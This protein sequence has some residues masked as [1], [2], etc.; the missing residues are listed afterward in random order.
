MSQLFLEI[1][2][3]ALSASWMILAVLL[4]RAVFKKIPKWITCLLWGMVALKLVLPFNIESA[5]SLIPSAR[6]IPADIAY[7]ASPRIDTGV[8]I[9]NGVINP[10]IS[11]SLPSGAAENAGNPF[12]SLLSVLAVIWVVGAAVMI[13]YAI[14]SFFLL[15][16]KV[17]ASFRRDKNIYECDEINIP[18]ILG[19]IRPRIYLPSGMDS[20]AMDCVLEHEQ[21]HIK[22][23]DYFWKPLGFFILSVY[24]FHPLCWAAYILLCKDIEL[25]CDEKATKDKDKEWKAAYCQA[26]LDCNGEKR[27]ITACPVAFGEVGVKDRVKLVLNYKRPS[28]WILAISIVLCIVMAVCFLTDPKSN[29]DVSDYQGIS[30]GEYQKLTGYQAEFYHA[31]YYIGKLPESELSIVFE[32]EYDEEAAAAILSEDS[33]AIRIEGTL[34]ELFGKKIR[35]LSEAELLQRISENFGDIISVDYMEGAGTAYYVGDYYAQ[36]LAASDSDDKI[37][38]VFE[39]AAEAQTGGEKTFSGGSAVWLGWEEKESAEENGDAENTIDY[40]AISAGVCNI[41][42]LGSILS[43]QFGK[44]I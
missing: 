19:I 14:I 33:K 38:M 28:F 21:T 17:S 27:M 13:L 29:F 31:L 24:W 20:A 42:R 5:L 16:R 22:R 30:Y 35:Q 34:S 10:I 1:L 37:N 12:Q 36:I 23:G 8:Q 25:A 18:F 4:F 11:H 32:A 26:L 2:N 39:I 40:E 43:I 41:Y 6:P 44:E 7:L 3:H 15:N 9:I